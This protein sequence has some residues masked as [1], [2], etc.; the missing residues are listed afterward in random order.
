MSL[1]GLG[2][3]LGTEPGPTELCCL[4]VSSAVAPSCPSSQEGP[5][6]QLIKQAKN[7]RINMR[8]CRRG[9]SI[10]GWSSQP[11]LQPCPTPPT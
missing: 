10:P 2:E 5:E 3:R 9:V 1:G 11:P 6:L 7:T 4:P 8:E